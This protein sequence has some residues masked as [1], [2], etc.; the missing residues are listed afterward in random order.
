MP[1]AEEQH[2]CKVCYREISSESARCCLACTSESAIGRTRNAAVLL[3]IAGFPVLIVGV[4]T[5]NAR[6]CL[7]G[8]LVSAVAV[9]L[10]AVLVVRQ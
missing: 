2:Y 9:L 6:A 3:G 4:L 7:V 5:L 1:N 10:Y 8:A